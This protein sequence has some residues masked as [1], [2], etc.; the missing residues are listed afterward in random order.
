MKQ[1]NAWSARSLGRHQVN[2]N[3][4]RTYAK[5]R[6]ELAAANLLR[7]QTFPL[8]WADEFA[9]IPFIKIIYGNMIPAMSKATEV[10]KKNAVPYG[11]LYTTTPGF[12]TNEEGKYAYKVVNNAT[13]FNENWYDLTY[14][15]ILE[16]KNDLNQDAR[17][18][19]SW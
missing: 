16:K 2:H 4:L 7:G 11:I 18:S 5:A 13:K 12:L 9:F 6:N 15:Q 14:S 19:R 17:N 3:K 8:L 1:H 10:A